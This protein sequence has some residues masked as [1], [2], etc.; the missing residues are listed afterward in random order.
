MSVGSKN[1][2]SILKWEVDSRK[3]DEIKKIVLSKS[4]FEE[5]SNQTGVYVGMEEYRVTMGVTY[6][7][8]VS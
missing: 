1:F 2:R 8:E 7:L 6:N 5:V 3:L 4:D